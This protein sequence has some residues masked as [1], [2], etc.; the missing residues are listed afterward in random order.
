MDRSA[1]QATFW[2]LSDPVRVEILDRVASGSQVTMTQLAE[3]LPMTRQAVSRHTRTL[4]KAGLLVGIKSGREL[5]Y[6]A[7]LRPL[8]E[9]EQWLQARTASWERALGRL[10]DYLESGEPSSK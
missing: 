2:A 9:A 1:S 6:R 3:V 4:E 5:R 7:D 10:A 8:D